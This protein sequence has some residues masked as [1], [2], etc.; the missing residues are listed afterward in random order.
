[1]EAFTLLVTFELQHKDS[2]RARG[3]ISKDASEIHNGGME[4]KVNWGVSGKVEGSGREMR[5]VNTIVKSSEG[6]VKSYGWC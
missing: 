3:I 1:M 2:F 6:Y 4:G 5:V